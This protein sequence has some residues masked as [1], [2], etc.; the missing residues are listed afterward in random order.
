MDGIVYWFCGPKVTAQLLVSLWTLRHRWQGPVMLLF[1]REVARIAERLASEKAFDLWL[2][3]VPLPATRHPHYVGKATLFEHAPFERTVLLDADT[4]VLG[5]LD[6]LWTDRLTTVQM[7]RWTTFTPRIR[8]RLKPWLEVDPP[9][10]SQVI[11]CQY[12]AVNTG[13]VAWG[14]RGGE[15]LQAWRELAVRGSH[16]PLTDELAMQLLVPELPW[17]LPDIYNH[18]ITYGTS[19]EEAVVVHFHGRRHLR[20]ENG[21]RW[22]LTYFAR[23]WQKDLAGCQE[24]LA[25]LCPAECQALREA[26]VPR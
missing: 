9:R 13:V 16:L 12:P 20:K 22:W 11:C 26:G 19:P 18:S 4:L 2:K 17:V 1:T 14:R 25:E 15:L 23:V 8:R 10:A 6:R 24:W 5:E 7:A 21:R 3:Q